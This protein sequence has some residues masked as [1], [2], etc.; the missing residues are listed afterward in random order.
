MLPI[1]PR[2][3]F[4]PLRVKPRA[5]ALGLFISCTALGCKEVTEKVVGKGVQVAKDATKGVSEGI[6]KGRKEGESSDGAVI[7]SKPEEVAGK[8][9]ITVRAL[10]VHSEQPK[11][12]EVELAFE[13]SGERPLRF[14][15]LDALA[16]DRENFV[17]RP[18][19]LSSELTVP[20]KAK[21]RLVVVFD[22]EAASLAKIRVWGTDYPLPAVSG[23][24]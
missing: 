2:S 14:T 4:S 8:G 5:V 11:Q 24:K 23:G 21:E 16:L 6:E 7:V 1:V 12:A 20:P 19:S 18:V 13:N 22:A 17:K 9:G 15:G 3:F 10:R